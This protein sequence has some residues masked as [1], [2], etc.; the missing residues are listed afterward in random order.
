MDRKYHAGTEPGETA[1]YAEQPGPAKSPRRCFASRPI[2]NEKTMNT[3][4]ISPAFRAEAWRYHHPIIEALLLS[5][6]SQVAGW[7]QTPVVPNDVRASIMA[8]VTNAFTPSIVVGLVNSNGTAFFSY[9][10]RNMDTDEPANE[11]SVFEI[12]SISKTFTCTVLSQMVL[13]GSLILTNPVETYLPENVQV[14]SR[15][16]KVI[17]L[18]HLA[19]H[20]SGLPRM[21]TNFEPS[22]ALNPYVDYTVQQ[23]YDF[24]GSYR[25]PRDPGATYEYS[26]IGMGLVG[27]VLSLK[28]GSD[29]ETLIA[30]RITRPLGMNDTGVAL[31][32]RMANNLALGYCGV[33]QTPN[34][35]LRSAF[36]GA[37]ALRASARDLL[38]YVAANMGLVRTDLYPAMTNAHSVIAAAGSNDSIGLG[39]FSTPIQGDQIISHTGGTG[40]YTTFAGFL[41][42]RKLG[43]VVLANCGS[44]SMGDIGL[45]LLDPTKALTSIRKP[46]VADLE[47]LRSCVGRYEVLGVDSFD[48]GLE[49]GHLTFAYSGDS[50]WKYTLYPSANRAFFAAVVE[51]GAT[52]RTN[53]QG[54]VKSLVWSQNGQASTYP[55][56]SV[57]ARLAI[58]R[59]NGE[60]QISFT[61]DTGVNYVLDATTNLTHWQPISTNTVWEQPIVDR[62]PAAGRF[63]RLRRP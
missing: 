19:T 1:G 60:N 56:V 5:L 57:P 36:A 52:F 48:I 14:P 16:G 9:G 21:P 17:T 34:W 45:H 54:Y 2:L 7:C 8:R 39:W 26:N 10:V 25:L 53:S 22:D 37:G 61:G 38:Q 13:N 59:H 40:G 24:L 27:H 6:A 32:A 62:E 50:G 41:R 43:A 35:D 55:K 33:V 42:S 15:N 49:H 20:R 58:Q 28:C 23:M 47:T 4:K 44:Y 63:Y 46:V 30:E 12:G 31:S 3:L 11:E 51:A 29:Y 18:K